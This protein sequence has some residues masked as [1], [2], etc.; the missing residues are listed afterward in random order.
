MK[1]YPFG[2][3]SIIKSIWIHRYLIW[4][5]TCREVLGRY[6]GSFLGVLWSFIT[7]VLMLLIFTF[8]FRTAF[9]AKWDDSYINSAG[10]FALILFVG[11]IIF[12]LISE[13][14]TKA[15]ILIIN[16]VNFVKKIVFP[17]EVLPLVTIGASI[18]HAF[19]CILVWFI[20]YILIN[21]APPIRV[22]L[23]PL[24][25]APLVFF[26]LG[27]S[28]LLASLGVYLR[29][30][31][32]VI[33]AGCQALMFMSPIFYPVSALPEKYQ[34]IIKL[35]PL[36]MVIEQGR[37]CLF[38]GVF[39]DWHTLLSAYILAFLTAWFGYV[40]FQKTRKGFADVL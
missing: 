34:W 23:L 39:P 30:I 13:S 25:I 21:G 1:N 35:N 20:G 10:N 37:D 32:Q 9:N 14:V 26:T 8:V 29:D 16:N 22:L 27:V 6:K 11:L 19:I 2:P 40:W 18:F 38:L 28:W 36:T 12:S 4:N 33:G 7:P 31:S 17:L 15:P 24:I 3:I 5:L